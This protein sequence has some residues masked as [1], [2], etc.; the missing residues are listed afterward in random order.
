VNGLAYQNYSAADMYSY[1]GSSAL[2][3][4]A[5][6]S[7]K[8]GPVRVGFAW[9][10]SSRALVSNS[11]IAKDASVPWAS[12][13]SAIYIGGPSTRSINGHVR[14]LAIYNSRLPDATLQAKS[15]VGA[16]YAAND[17][18]IRY[19]FA[20]NDNLPIHWRVAL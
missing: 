2:T 10:A 20:D 3:F 12:A 14:S 6:D 4:T 5:F 11:T 17:N 13:P 15:V 18:G 16:S 8:P 1:N 19:A 7:L 9:D